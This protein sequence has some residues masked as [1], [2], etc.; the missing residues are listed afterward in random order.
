MLFIKLNV[1]HANFFPCGLGM[2]YVCKKLQDF[3]LLL[4]DNPKPIWK[5]DVQVIH[6]L[7][8]NVCIS[9]KILTIGF[10]HG[11]KA[12]SHTRLRSRDHYTSSTLIG[13][14]AELVQVHFTLRLR[15]HRSM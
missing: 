5:Q 8:I 14:K 10:E 2:T 4:V 12:T 7:K 6:V 1:I 3:K 15:D 13:G 9:Y 11:V